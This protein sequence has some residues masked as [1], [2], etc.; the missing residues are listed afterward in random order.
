M[1]TLYLI[2]GFKFPS[3]SDHHMKSF[4]VNWA[5]GEIPEETGYSKSRRTEELDTLVD[6]RLPCIN[7]TQP[8]DFSDCVGNKKMICTN[9]N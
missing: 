6:N 1:L 8:S 3:W 9:S 5:K 4:P 2:L 7:C